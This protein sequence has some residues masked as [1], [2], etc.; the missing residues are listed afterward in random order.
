MI[1]SDSDKADLTQLASGGADRPT[2]ERADSLLEKRPEAA[3]YF[4]RMKR[5]SD[6]LHAA[7]TTAEGL[8]PEERLSADEVSA[9]VAKVSRRAD[10][11]RSRHVRRRIMAVAAV[12]ALVVTPLAAWRIWVHRPIGQAIIFHSG[13]TLNT[14]PQVNRLTVRAGLELATGTD[15][16]AVQ[17]KQ[18]RMALSP[19]SSVRFDRGGIVLSAGSVYVSEAR[20]LQVEAD[21]VSLMV[22]GD[23]WVS[24][25]PDGMTCSVHKGSA[26][27]TSSG[28]EQTIPLDAQLTVS[29]QGRTVA[30]ASKVLPHWVEASLKLLQDEVAS[31]K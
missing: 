1:L 9:I 5:E 19:E 12:I 2:R 20:Q 6:L 24:I 13:F 25:T 31:A 30:R 29:G 27:V 18:G 3:Q 16:G 17:L 14:G 23:A 21:G 4:A 22:E 7:F 15:Y 28:F 11:L 8:I 10:Q 26:S